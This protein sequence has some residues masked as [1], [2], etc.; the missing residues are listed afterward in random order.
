[1][2]FSDIL[3]ESANMNFIKLPKPAK[4]QNNVE[5]RVALVS[6]LKKKESIPSN[7]SIIEPAATLRKS[8]TV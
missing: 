5:W 2:S 1:M 6:V 8:L 4:I 7:Q 3:S